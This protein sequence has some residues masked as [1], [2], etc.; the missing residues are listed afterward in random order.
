[1]IVSLAVLGLLIFAVSFGINQSKAFKSLCSCNSRIKP[2]EWIFQKQNKT[3]D[4]LIKKGKIK[5]I[6]NKMVVVE[7]EDGQILKM[8][9]NMFCKH[10]MNNLNINEEVIISGFNS[11]NGFKPSKGKKGLNN[12]SDCELKN[13]IKLNNS[14]NNI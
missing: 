14:C 9:K 4:S 7:L 8:N 5:E 6:Q 3:Y 2:L 1:M 13:E 11:K 10:C 12:C